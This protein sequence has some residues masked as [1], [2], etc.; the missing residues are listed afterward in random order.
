M[1]VFPCYHCGTGISLSVKELQ[2]FF[3]TPDDIKFCRLS[4]ME[5]YIKSLPKAANPGSVPTVG[6]RI[7]TP[8]TNY[9]SDDYPVYE[10]RTQGRFRSVIEAYTAYWLMR[11]QLPYEYESRVIE[12]EGTLHYTPD[13]YIPSRDL[14]IEVKGAWRNN[15]KK[16]FKASQKMGYNIILMPWIMEPALKRFYNTRGVADE[17]SSS[18]LR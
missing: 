16:K 4:C 8:H 7:I 6:G 3:C 17:I 11:C 5:S 1:P 10:T 9:V 15:S 2:K 13:F 12:V 14:F 18:R